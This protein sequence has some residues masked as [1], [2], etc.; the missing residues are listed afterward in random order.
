M[1]KSEQYWVRLPLQMAYNVRELGGL[2]VKNGKQTAWHRFLR[3]DDISQLTEQ[4]IGFLLDYGVSTVI[5]LRS[6]AEAG[7]KPDK[8]NQEY[9]VDHHFIP[10]IDK[11]IS[12]EGGLDFF[13]AFGGI[14]DMYIDFL[15]NCR[16]VR[17]LFETIATAK[18]G[19]VLYHCAG[20]KDRTGILSLLLLM[21]AGVDQQD[22]QIN[23][24][25]S[26]LNLTRDPLFKENAAS[27]PDRY[28]HFLESRLEYIQPAYQYVAGFKGGVE[29]YLIH[30]GLRDEQ[31][32][33]VK[34]RLLI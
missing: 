19:C 11:D 33:L 29:G 12:P 10:F 21:L 7:Q 18:P 17:E 6:E 14:G 22:C 16:V 28:M 32:A 5:D 30:C 15:L 24:I 23:Y 20:G 4:D 13:D 8:L 34:E 27:I 2:P 9:G 3:A 1:K 31:L 26:F 25:Q